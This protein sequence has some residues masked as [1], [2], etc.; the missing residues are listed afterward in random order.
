MTTQNNALIALKPSADLSSKKGYFVEASSGGKAAVVDAALDIPLGVVVDGTSTDAR[1]TV[2]LQNYGGTLEIKVVASTPGTIT[3][4]TYLQLTA[5]GTV[6]ADVGSNKRVLV[7]R[8]LEKGVAAGLVEA[9][10]INPIT[11]S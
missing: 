1:S 7:A 8:A 5:D 9:I 10:L 4:G 6:K 11:L 2:A 3:L